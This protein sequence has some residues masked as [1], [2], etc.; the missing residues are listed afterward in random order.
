MKKLF[1]VSVFILCF[2]MMNA[3]VTDALKIKIARASYSDETIIRYL[4]SATFGFDSNYDAY[5][6]F[7]FNA[8]VPNIFTKDSAAE[9]LSINAMP[10]FSTRTTTDVFLKIGTAGTYSITPE[11]TGPFT[12]GVCIKMKDLST[13]QLYEMRTAST[14]T[15]S[16]PVIAQTAPARFRVYFSYPASFTYVSGNSGNWSSASSWKIPECGCATATAAPSAGN[17]V[18]INSGNTVTLDS[19]FSCTNLTVNGTFTANADLTISGNWTNSGTFNAGANKITF[20]GSALQIISG[21]STSAFNNLTINNSTPA[22]A[23]RLNAPATVNGTLTLKDGH[24]TTSSV[25]ILTCGSSASIALQCFPQDSSFVK[26]PL[27]HIVNSDYGITKLFPVGKNNSYRRI[28]LTLDQQTSDSTSYTAEM[29]DSSAEALGYTKPAGISNASYVRYHAISQSPAT[30]LDMG[31]VRIYFGCAGVNDN[32]QTLPPVTVLQDDGSA[33]WVDLSHTPWGFSCGSNY[34]GNM[35]SGNFSSFNGN[36]FSLANTGGAPEILGVTMMDFSAKA[37]GRIVATTWATASES[38]TSSFALE[39]SKDGTTFSTVEIIN[40]AGN[41]S[42]IIHYSAQDE[43]PYGGVSYYRLKETDSNGNFSY[44]KIVSV[45]LQSENAVSV[46]PNPASEIIH[47]TI[48]ESMGKESMLSIRDVLG[49]EHYTAK[50]IPQSE[51]ETLSI[52]VENKF[53]AGIYFVTVSNMDKTS[54]EKII[55][56]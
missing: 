50:T 49:K 33:A 41:S 18:T 48:S 40:A 52:P 28:D 17:D 6:L 32:V 20:N 42:A 22:E 11:E 14:Y 39:R 3:Q 37:E 45:N 5:K 29:I 30:P 1:A 56:K 35:L 25:N 12:S 19:N 43:N 4:D 16:L 24:I 54:E 55:I 27:R 46:Y 38:S 44:S 26:G 47:V 23:L 51:N 34:W 31:Q 10:E 21:S 9:E 13:G 36:K 2:Q 53:P 7:S 8:A 15:I